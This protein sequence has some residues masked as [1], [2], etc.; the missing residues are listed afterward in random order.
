MTTMRSPLSR[1]GPLLPLLSLLVAGLVVAGCGATG[2]GGESPARTA[3]ATPSATEA[4]PSQAPASPSPRTGPTPVPGGQTIAPPGPTGV[5]TTQTDWGAILDAVPASFPAYPGVKAADSVDGPVSAS[6][7]VEAATDTVAPWYQKA[8]EAKGWAVTLS[9]ALEDGSRVLDAASDL[10]EC[11]VR[12]DFRPAAGS[13]M[14]SVL[15]AAGCAG[16]GG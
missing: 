7:T 3:A 14:I 11:M 4:A 10:P 2:G 15:Y 9:D 16:A 8:L 12:M 6:L 1:T 13:T 5:P